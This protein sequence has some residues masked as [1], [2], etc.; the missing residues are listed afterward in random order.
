MLTKFQKS[1]HICIK[2]SVIQDKFLILCE[3]CFFQNQYSVKNFILFCQS[4]NLDILYTDKQ[5][6]VLAAYMLMQTK[7]FTFLTDVKVLCIYLACLLLVH[8]LQ[9]SRFLH[10]SIHLRVKACHWPFQKYVIIIHFHCY[11]DLLSSSV[12][13][14]HQSLALLMGILP[15]NRAISLFSMMFSKICLMSYFGKKET[16]VQDILPQYVNPTQKIC[17]IRLYIYIYIF[18]Y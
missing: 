9:C 10:W 18:L 3:N 4:S 1:F 17:K 15:L 7:C 14:H 2:R 5:K 13:F 16:N 6:N 11:H 12:I 8:M